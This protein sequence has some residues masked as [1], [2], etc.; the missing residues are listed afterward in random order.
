MKGLIRK[1]LGIADLESNI[2]SLKDNSL[3][4][5]QK[6]EQM[7]YKLANKDVTLGKLQSS[8]DKAILKQEELN[9]Y[10]KTHLDSNDTLSY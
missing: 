1:W 4:L 6:Y 9:A 10:I 7:F 3:A 8:I 5:Q 2:E